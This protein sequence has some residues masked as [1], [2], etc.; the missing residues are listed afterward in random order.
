MA[1]CPQPAQTWLQAAAAAANIYSEE[2]RQEETTQ[3][4]NYDV[5]GDAGIIQAGF[6]SRG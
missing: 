2:E 1:G 5:Q 4:S 6:G 3:Y